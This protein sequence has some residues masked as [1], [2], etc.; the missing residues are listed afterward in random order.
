[1]L[2]GALE[3]NRRALL[4]GTKTF[5]EGLVHSLQPLPDGSGL[6]IAVARFQTPNGSEVLGKGIEPNVRAGASDLE[7][8]SRSKRDAD[9]QYKKAIKTLL[10]ELGR[11][12]HS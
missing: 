8:E 1:M 11:A 12:K 9:P 5:G 7:F 4:V 10:A 2:A 3:D 6:I